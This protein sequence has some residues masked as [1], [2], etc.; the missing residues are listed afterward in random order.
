MS[1]EDNE[2][3]NEEEYHFAVDPE[4]VERNDQPDFQTIEE[5]PKSRFDFSKLLDRKKIKELLYENVQVRNA[6]IALVV[7][8]LLVIVYRFTSGIISKKKASEA[9]RNTFQQPQSF[10]TK[11]A[12]LEPTIEGKQGSVSVLKNEF[13]KET[14]AINNSL[15]K[16]KESQ[17]SINAKISTVT[18]DNIKMANQYQDLSEKLNKL[19]MQI[20]KLSSAVE[21]QSQSIV[22]LSIRREHPP[23]RRQSR[24]QVVRPQF[25]R[26]FVK[27]VI[28][29]R[30][31]LIAE[32]GSTLTVR[33]G[34]VVPGYGLVT[35]VDVS[36]GQVMTSSGKIITFAQN[37][38]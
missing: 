16:V 23:R 1:K 8:V 30:A 9:V 4:D 10:E 38:S 31:W 12:K 22:S 26:Y 33:K 15:M 32:N 18:E 28:P 3:F 29:G 19:A 2:N 21:D 36:Q 13:D 20:E 37:D 24:Q 11:D 27:A 7:L 17:D 14:K 25:M 6:I 5:P 34:S 35:M